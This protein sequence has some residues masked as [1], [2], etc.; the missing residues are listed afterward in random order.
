MFLV[1][2]SVWIDLLRQY[3]TG[4]VRILRSLFEQRLPYGIT[5]IIYQE[6]L[7]GARSEMDF[8]KLREYLGTQCFYHPKE[9]VGSYAEAARLYA[10]CRRQGITIRSTIDC[11]IARI[12]IE[13]ELTLLHSDKDYIYLAQ[14]DPRL[15]LANLADYES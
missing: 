7:Q 2:T 11:L 9:S 14:I 3:D 8:D 1:D 6:V 15:K 13:H 12:A 10:D 5:G 4:P